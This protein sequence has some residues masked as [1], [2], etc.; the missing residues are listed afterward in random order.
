M[1]VRVIR[2][3]MT[4]LESVYGSQ[5]AYL[6]MGQAASVKELTRRI[7]IPNVNSLSGNKRNKIQVS[8]YVQSKNQTFFF[9]IH[10][11]VLTF[12]WS[13]RASVDPETNQRSSS[14]T[15]RQNTRFV[16]NSGSVS[17]HSE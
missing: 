15:P 10:S 5:V 4:P 8:H 12:A 1:H 3:K 11:P 6:S 7:P 14:A 13:R 9:V 2:S 16:V 17:S